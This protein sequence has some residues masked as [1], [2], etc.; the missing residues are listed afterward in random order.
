MW[1][2]PYGCKE[3]TKMQGIKYSREAVSNNSKRAKLKKQLSSLVFSESLSI[4]MSL[5]DMSRE[6]YR[7]FTTMFSDY[8]SPRRIRKGGASI[9]RQRK[10]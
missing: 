6:I 7:D 8:A 2:L 4:S 3:V 1:Y 9:G 10:K 5:D